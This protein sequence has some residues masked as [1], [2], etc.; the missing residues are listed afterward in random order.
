[1]KQLPVTPAKSEQ[2]GSLAYLALKYLALPTVLL[3]LNQLLPL[4]IPG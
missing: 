2:T 3:S 4:M 1:M